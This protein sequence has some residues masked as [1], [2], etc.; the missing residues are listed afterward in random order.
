MVSFIDPSLPSMTWILSFFKR[1][2]VRPVAALDLFDRLAMFC[3]DIA[4][5][6]DLFPFD[7]ARGFIGLFRRRGIPF[8]RG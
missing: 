8:P 3:G 1:R 5:D 4:F 2:W 6:V 7:Q